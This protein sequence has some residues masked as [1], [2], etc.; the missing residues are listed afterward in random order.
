MI[1]DKELNISNESYTKKDFYQI[2][3]EILD[4]ITRITERWHP[5]TSNES[6]P[7]VVLI[8]LLAFI[9][10]KNNYNI[11][12]NILECF[13]PSAT[14][15]ESMR[16]LCDMMGYDMKYYRSAKTDISFTWLGDSSLEEGSNFKFT[17]P[18]YTTTIQ[19]KEG[20][21]TYT[22]IG[23]NLEFSVDNINTND[24]QNQICEAI[25]GE[26]IRLT[27]GGS[28]I[29]TLENIDNKHRL[30]LPETSVAENGIFIEFNDPGKSDKTWK[31][32]D[33]LNI[34]LSG[35]Y[36]WKFGFD[37]LKRLPYIQFPDDIGDLIEDGLAV[38][39]T[40]T[41]GANGNVSANVLTKLTSVKEVVNENDETQSLTLIT[42]SAEGTVNLI[43][44]NKFSTINGYDPE[45][46][47][48][49]YNN[50]KKTVGT[51]D[52]LVTCRDYAN[53]I[54]QMVISD[55]D[56]SPLVSNCQVSD[57]RTDVFKAST[58]KTFT[59]FGEG[60]I[61]I[62]E[63]DSETDQDVI[64]HFDL[65]LYPLKRVGT[66]YT[67]E[68]YNESFKP[69]SNNIYDI[70]QKLDDYKTL[71]HQFKN[72][73]GNDLYLIKNYY[74]LSG[75]ITTTY[76]VAAAEATEIL[77]NVY[78]ALYK[79]FNARNVDYGYEINSDIISSVIK[80]S[81]YRI[82]NVDLNEPELDARFMLANGN[83]YHKEERAS[84]SVLTNYEKVYIK[85][86]AK[87]ILAGR[88][89]LF[90]YDNSFDYNFNREPYISE[91]TLQPVGPII[92][93][94]TNE[95]LQI[96]SLASEFA[97]P[98]DNTQTA[99]DYTLK[100]NEVIQFR[101]PN[102]R[103]TIIYPYMVNYYLDLY[104]KETAISANEEYQLQENDHLYINYT[105]GEDDSSHT[106]HNISYYKD[107]N[108]WYENDNGNI[109]EFSGIIKFNFNVK[110]SGIE[111]H[112]TYAKRDQK[113]DPS[114]TVVTSAGGMIALSAKE[115]SD[116]R[117][118]VKVT[119]P[120]KKKSGSLE[121][122]SS[123]KFY[124]LTESGYLFD[125]DT[126]VKTLG[127]NEYFFYTNDAE[128]ELYAFGSG[129]VITTSLS[130]Q[131]AHAKYYIDYSAVKKVSTNDV[132]NNGL[133]AF[134][135]VRWK[136]INFTTPNELTCQEMQF[137]TLTE[138]DQIKTITGYE[139]PS[140][141]S[142]DTLHLDNTF[143]PLTNAT[144]RMLNKDSSLPL[145]TGDLTWEVRSRFDINCSST[146]SEVLYEYDNIKAFN[147]QEQ[148]LLNIQ[149]S[150]DVSNSPS[151]NSNYAILKEGNDFISAKILD[152][153][154]KELNNLKLLVF[155]NVEISNEHIDLYN[156]DDN[157]TKLNLDYLSVDDKFPILIPSDS[158]AAVLMVYYTPGD[159]EW[160]KVVCEDQD[161]EQE[162]G[163]LCFYSDISDV[164][165]LPQLKPE[166]PLK[167][168]I[169]VIYIKN[170]VNT[171]HF[172]SDTVES[173][174]YKGTLILGNY[175]IIAK[176]KAG[177]N[178]E[179]FN[180]DNTA[181][182]KLLSYLNNY[183]SIVTQDN[184]LNNVF[185]YNYPVKSQ[186][187]IDTTAKKLDELF[188][189]D[190]NNVASK[191]VLCELDTNELSN[192]VISKQ[193]RRF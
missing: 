68:S 16:K 120:L 135:D 126:T 183:G 114:W 190:V 85:L 42:D 15:E 163:Y 76:K 128:T 19:N 125:E 161:S 75:K 2:Y 141:D 137:I 131:T 106:V 21:I 74:K 66:S 162:T 156:Y 104:N 26:V 34:E 37:S 157:Y 175:S 189:F 138:G 32:T 29:I 43:I 55:N 113:W 97:L 167:P 53:K 38:W 177:I 110:D 48:E 148:I 24:Y 133:N 94:D 31:Q 187:A 84:A 186:E 52:T 192:I 3:P 149:G 176:E 159:E 27:V 87:N 61:S 178:A 60:D 107:G 108:K 36:R 44:S 50:F 112:P 86:V 182:T 81:D 191:F 164:T 169:N 118:F 145:L 4:L 127:E 69:D 45:T 132:A 95:A 172:S 65:Y 184:S 11:D 79:N 59:E 25:E 154:G 158:H 80:N 160:V 129:T 9:A 33:N 83:E 6:D 101:A 168:G 152:T 64:N 10:D 40:R 18:K 47:D 39:Y 30:Y 1:T 180:F 193:S 12:K 144:Y 56:A 171:I 99:L 67:Y 115:Q 46:L 17:L 109:T 57:I 181:C 150:D 146:L 140:L 71:S 165:E 49:A 92:G 23:K 90:K 102:L 147:K 14:Q 116:I 70:Q 20:D 188:W 117:D 166:L 119:F 63:R 170:G 54:Y 5:E 143:Q 93:D 130:A 98:I 151:I 73:V 173:G 51:F 77:S 124:W 35:S 8:K 136:K 7:G 103:S 185:Y 22:L 121:Y 111:G 88:L 62:S 13:M 142:E 139:N 72:P 155:K 58:V 78:T 123:R 134:S 179:L 91:S 89:S 100:A 96:Y 105:E 122:E 153:N 174:Q 41:T 82:K 28:D